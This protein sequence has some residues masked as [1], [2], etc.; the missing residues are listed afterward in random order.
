MRSRSLIIK[1]FMLIAISLASFHSRAGLISINGSSVEALDLNGIYNSFEEFYDY[2]D[3]FVWSSNTGFEVI[4]TVVFF[5]AE[6]NNEYGIF[7]TIS[8]A[9]GGSKG[10]VSFNYAATSGSMLFLDDPDEKLDGST[11]VFRYAQDRSDGFIYGGLDNNDWSFSASF[12]DETNINGIGFVSFD[13]GELSNPQY[14][15]LFALDDLFTISNVGA[16]SSQVSQ[17]VSEPGSFALLIIGLSGLLARR[18][19]FKL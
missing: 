7:S 10:K 18:S 19:K 3:A 6:L 13:N 8:S 14:S 17:P 1:S 16:D 5:V 11:I 12:F 15:S 4:D 2:D 9:N